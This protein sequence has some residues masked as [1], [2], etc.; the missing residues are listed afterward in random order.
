M[1]KGIEKIAVEIV[2]EYHKKDDKGRKNELTNSVRISLNK[3]AN[4]IDKGFNLEVRVAPITEE[5]TESDENKGDE[6][7]KSIATIQAATP[8]MQFMNLEGQPILRL[9]ETEKKQKKEG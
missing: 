5:N 9:P 3:I 2:S 7:K 8:N 4:R 6:L 1:E